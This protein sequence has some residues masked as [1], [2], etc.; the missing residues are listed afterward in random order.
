LNTRL[1]ANAGNR[2][3]LSVPTQERTGVTGLECWQG[4]SKTTPKR[5]M[6]NYL[7]DCVRVSPARPVDTSKLTTAVTSTVQ[8]IMADKLG[9]LQMEVHK[10]RMDLR[11]LMPMCEELKSCLTEALNTKLDRLSLM[12]D[13]RLQDVQVCVR[14]IVVRRGTSSIHSC[15]QAG[16]RPGVWV[17]W[18]GRQATSPRL[19]SGC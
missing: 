1:L 6:D 10:L 11:S 2:L 15:S 7:A 19:C 17:G 13:V 3:L 4:A 12:A 9:G 14:L 18:P 8:G 16:L 5:L